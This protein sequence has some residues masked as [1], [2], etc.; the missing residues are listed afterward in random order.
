MNESPD[1]ELPIAMPLSLMLRPLNDWLRDAP[2]PLMLPPSGPAGWAD[3][4]SC[5]K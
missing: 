4:M 3:W 1:I 2:T 5:G